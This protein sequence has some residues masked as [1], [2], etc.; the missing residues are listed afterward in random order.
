[1]KHYRHIGLIE[2]KLRALRHWLNDL[3]DEE[4]FVLSLLAGVFC[5]FLQAYF[6]G[7]LQ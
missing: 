4:L 7:G 1:M 3:T 2:R 6:F 5:L